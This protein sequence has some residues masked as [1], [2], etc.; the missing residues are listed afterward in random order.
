MNNDLISRSALLDLFD[1]KAF[2]ALELY[3][4]GIAREIW[5]EAFEAVK[6][7]PSVD[8]EPVRHE[9]NTTFIATSN[10][11]S[12][13]DRIIVGQNTLCKVYYADEPVRHGRWVN[14]TERIY[15]DLNYR[16]DCSA[17]SH[18]FYAAGIETFK[19]CPN[20]GAKMDAEVDE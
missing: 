4:E 15:A 14:K 1:A 9:S 11:D 17:C 20:C 5:L 3:D 18:I 8:A 16:F 12:Y 13:A 2:S 7:A 19:Y 10:L 6:N